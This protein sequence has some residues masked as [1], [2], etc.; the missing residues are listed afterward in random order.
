MLGVVVNIGIGESWDIPEQ[1]IFE[2][3]RARRLVEACPFGGCGVVWVLD[4][5]VNW[6][7]TWENLGM[8]LII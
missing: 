7:E 8:Y 2:G 6:L 4:V 5:K 3:F 1:N